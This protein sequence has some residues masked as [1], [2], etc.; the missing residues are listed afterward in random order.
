MW[1]FKKSPKP[2]RSVRDMT[3]A[4]LEPALCDLQDRISRDVYVQ[5]RKVDDRLYLRAYR[6]E[7]EYD[8]G[9]PNNKLDDVIKV[10]KS[11]SNDIRHRAPR[12]DD[13]T[14]VCPF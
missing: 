3:H 8:L 10:F 11:A 12:N 1:P 13:R 6:M 4:L 9:V 2:Q 7:V 14:E 5:L